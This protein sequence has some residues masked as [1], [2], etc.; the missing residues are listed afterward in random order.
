MFPVDPASNQILPTCHYNTLHLS[1][2]PLFK[3]EFP[4]VLAILPSPAIN[5]VLAI[6]S[7]N[8]EPAFSAQQEGRG[9]AFPTTVPIDTSTLP[10]I[11]RLAIQAGLSPY[12][13]MS[14][15]E[16]VCWKTGEAHFGDDR[17]HK[18]FSRDL[19]Y[20]RSINCICSSANFPT[21]WLGWPNENRYPHACR[22][23]H[24]SL[25]SCYL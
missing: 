1:G 8:S 22:N 5:I 14:E 7:S 10:V 17:G 3:P 23:T 11:T 13:S 2:I 12:K 21:L 24:C 4:L 15:S 9:F 20:L 16:P 19:L 18:L 6:S 25:L